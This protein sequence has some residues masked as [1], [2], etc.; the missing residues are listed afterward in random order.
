[1]DPAFNEKCADE[2]A[3]GLTES[4][5]GSVRVTQLESEL[6]TARDALK[7]ISRLATEWDC[8]QMGGVHIQR[9]RWKHLGKLA[10]EVIQSTPNPTQ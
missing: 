9:K 2:L 3:E 10:D 1:M 8:N 6:K 5:W 7:K 4:Q